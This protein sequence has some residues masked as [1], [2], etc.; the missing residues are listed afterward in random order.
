MALA[1]SDVIVTKWEFSA[2]VMNILTPSAHAETRNGV[3]YVDSPLE[4]AEKWESGK[5]FYVEGN[6]PLSNELLSSLQ[7]EISVKYPNTDYTFFFTGKNP[8][9]FRYK[10]RN[11]KTVRWKD[12]IDFALDETLQGQT[13]M[14]VGKKYVVFWISFQPDN[15]GTRWARALP[16]EEFDA[17]DMWENDR[18]SSKNGPVFSKVFPQLK[19][20][21]YSWAIQILTTSYEGE[22]NRVINK[23]K[24]DKENAESS[25]S[26][27]RLYFEWLKKDYED[28]LWKS[29][30]LS[31]WSEIE[32]Y[33]QSAENSL[34]SDSIKTVNNYIERAKD[35]IDEKRELI[36][37]HE[38]FGEKIMNLRSTLEQSNASKH[39]L[40]ASTEYQEATRLLQIAILE[41]EQKDFKYIQ[42]YQNADKWYRKF[43]WKIAKISTVN[44]VK[45]WSIPL[46]LTLSWI[47][48]I[49]RNRK[50]RPAKNVFEH[51]IKAFKEWLLRIEESLWEILPGKDLTLALMN[52]EY[53][54]EMKKK[55]QDFRNIF[56]ELLYTIPELNKFLW[57]VQKTVD[58]YKLNLISSSGYNAGREM[59]QK[60]DIFINSADAEIDVNLLEKLGFKEGEISNFEE[61]TNDISKSFWYAVRDTDINVLNLRN[62]INEIKNINE[63]YQSNLES[64][65]TNFENLSKSMD[66]FSDID[67]FILWR[68]SYFSQVFE[69]NFLKNISIESIDDMI[70]A[71]AKLEKVNKKISVFSVAIESI[72]SHISENDPDDIIMTLQDSGYETKW[73]SNNLPRAFNLLDGQTEDIVNDEMSFE[74]FSSNIEQKSWNIKSLYKKLIDIHNAIEDKHNL[75][76]KIK[77]FSTAVAKKRTMMTKTYKAKH[78][79][80]INKADLFLEENKPLSWFFESLKP[81]DLEF[82]SHV[83]KWSSEEI[84]SLISK[85]NEMMTEAQEIFDTTDLK[86]QGYTSH[87]S[88]I[89]ETSVKLE[90]DIE[91]ALFVLNDIKNH[92]DPKVLVLWEGDPTHPDCDWDL[93]NN[94]E[95]ILESVRERDNLVSFAQDEFNIWKVIQSSKSLDRAD[96]MN[97]N[98]KYRI[99]EIHDKHQ[100]IDQIENL[101]RKKLMDIQ[102]VFKELSGLTKEHYVVEN[103]ISDIENLLKFEKSLVDMQT[104]KKRNP[105]SIQEKFAYMDTLIQDV[106]SKIE[107][108][109]QVNANLR[110]TFQSIWKQI[111]IL[112]KEWSSAQNDK[113]PDSQEAKKVFE[114]K[115]P[116]YSK[117]YEQLLSELKKDHNNW[118]KLYKKADEIEEDIMNWIKVLRKDD[119]ERRKIEDAIEQASQRS[120]SARSWRGDYGIRLR[121]DYGSSDL[122]TALEL[123]ALWRFLDASKYAKNSYEKASIQI[124]RADS[125]VQE[126][127]TR[128]RRAREEEERRARKR[129]ED[130][131]RRRRNSYSSSSSGFWSSGGWF[132]WGSS[133]FGSSGWGW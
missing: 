5:S 69:S 89:A 21:N 86:F 37:S 96:I 110:N 88:N 24:R 15:S 52:M 38:S 56:S 67:S 3:E 17:L 42:S 84:T 7:S 70:G 57:N 51:D 112:T 78:K 104:A 93:G 14:G 82:V 113:Y 92:W 128:R 22:Y 114:E 41:W 36:N 48:W 32:K 11:G 45:K 31:W 28:F 61:L 19:S 63:I 107:K 83:N 101:N 132:W 118:Y 39:A 59:I 68:F 124:S 125:A 99:S 120:K 27:T 130:A 40:W 105:F 47:W 58:A 116:E 111:L 4:V 35:S 109:R 12:A 119:A 77:A 95:E 55:V 9:N 85:M 60:W 25:I 97:N 13:T 33:L 49:G 129:R 98:I 64:V 133:G 108:D 90:E 53:K 76:E 71:N 123:Y 20:G 87:Q 122:D 29:A 91:P 100:R 74:D 103:T 54:W 2:K 94:M 34:E 30:P 10:N 73:F 43:K 44:V 23:Q 18:F 117:A 72:I 80:D 102:S 6:I 1:L 81:L 46:W 65:K 121:W 66:F 8:D 131:A 26:T 106:K 50:R 115:I 79:I 75:S 126:E 127:R 62:I 16:S